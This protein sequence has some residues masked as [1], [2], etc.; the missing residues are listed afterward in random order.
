KSKNMAFDNPGMPAELDWISKEYNK[1]DEKGF[2]KLVPI[3]A[4]GI[5][6]GETGK[7]WRGMN[8]PPGKHWQLSPEK[9][10]ELD[11]NGEIHWSKTGNPR[12]KVYLTQDK[13]LPLTDYWDKF[14]DAHH[15]SIK[16]TGYPTEKNFD[17]LKKIIEASTKAG[18]IVLD[19]F[20]GS[21]T[22]LHA[23]QELNRK[24]LGIDQS[25]QAIITS[26]RRL[27]FGLE[28]MGDFVNTKPTERN[29]GLKVADKK[30]NF[31]VDNDV[32]CKHTKEIELL[33][34]ECS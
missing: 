28:P 6:N 26:I 34:N 13:K 3:H 24:W 11:N 19:P 31:I 33:F 9:L 27:N 2:F 4:P 12:R 1:K 20:C 18:D 30:F 5:R 22:T 21:G 7:P 23:A 25:F 17:M 29:K 15:Q 14:R 10:E 16:I 8:P 32:Y